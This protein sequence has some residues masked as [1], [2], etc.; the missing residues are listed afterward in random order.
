ME[1]QQIVAAEENVENSASGKQSITAR[2]TAFFE[3]NY[4]LFFAPFA[5]LALYVMTLFLYHVYP[6]SNEKTVASYDL[7]AQI[8]PFIEH[9]FDVLDGKSTL[10]YTYAIVGGVDVTGTFL[11]FFVSPFSFL[12]L[13]FGDGMVARAAGVVMALKLATTAFAGTWFAKNLF[14]NF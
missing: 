12:F 8:C 13:I 10:S 4:A 1:Q 14:K 2:M 3:K 6:F 5:V 11:Y 9:L 7:S